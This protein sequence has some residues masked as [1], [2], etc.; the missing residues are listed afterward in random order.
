MRDEREAVAG[1]LLATWDVVGV[2]QTD[3]R[4]EAE[5]LFEADVVLARLRDGADAAAIAEYLTQVA[6]ELSF[7]SRSRDEAAASALLSWW[8]DRQ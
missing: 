3:E 5:Y 8:Q 1:I 2:R 4:P 6:T 7:A